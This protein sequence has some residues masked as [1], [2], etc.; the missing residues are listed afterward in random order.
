MPPFRVALY[1]RKSTA[2]DRNDA[3]RSVTRQLELGRAFAESQGWQVVAKFADDGVSGRETA[4]LVERARMLTEALAGG[5]DVVVVRD[6]DRLSRDDREGPAFVYML[7]DAG[8]QTWE[9]L[10]RG[11]IRVERALDRTMLTMKAGFAAHEAEAA[12]ERTRDAKYA[13]AAAGTIAD[14]RVL[15]YRTVGPLASRRREIDPDQGQVVRRIFTMAAEGMGYLRI[16]RTLN[17]ER[18]VNPSGQDRRDTTK[19]TEQWSS[20]GI[21]AILYR[22][23]YRGRVVYGQTRNVRPRGGKRR[24]VAGDR[25]VVVE[26]PELRIVDE[27]LWQRAHERRPTTRHAATAPGQGS[28][29]LLSGLC[30]CGLCGGGLIVSRKT[31]RR[32][33]A[34]T[35][36]ICTR[37]RHR[38]D[39]GCT[40]RW[41]VDV[42]ELTDAVV[43]KIRHAF[44]NPVELGQCLMRELER[45]RQQPDAGAVIEARARVRQVGQVVGRLV[46]AIAIHGGESRALVERLRGAEAEERDARAALEHAEGQALAAGEPI[47]AGELVEGLRIVLGDELRKALETDDVAAGR[48]ALRAGSLARST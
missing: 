44:L 28:P 7:S 14:G 26:R 25:P 32:G 12:T 27:A 17:R 3:D 40:N 45:S 2:D 5:F 18:V 21:R 9:Y 29:Y 8:V 22:D 24:K 47:D 46:E 20:S 19:R 11:P 35:L 34:Q 30:A 39:E 13:K 36:L 38:G 16:A 15:G 37:R 48:R 1:A 43:D 23:L 41:G 6:F 31:G 10:S 33:R 4:R 42:D